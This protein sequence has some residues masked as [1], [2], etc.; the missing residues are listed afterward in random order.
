VKK[1]DSIPEVEES[2]RF[3]GIGDSE[4]AYMDL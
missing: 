4:I 1:P 2:F 3:A